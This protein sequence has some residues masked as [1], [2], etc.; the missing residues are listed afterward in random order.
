MFPSEARERLAVLG[1]LPR[2]AI[3]PRRSEWSAPDWGF[4]WA[5]P[6]SVQSMLGGLFDLVDRLG[7]VQDYGDPIDLDTI[8]SAGKFITKIKFPLLGLDGNR[9][10]ID[11]PLK[12]A[13]ATPP[14]LTHV[15]GFPYKH[16]VRVHLQNYWMAPLSPGYLHDNRG[17]AEISKPFVAALFLGLHELGLTYYPPFSPDGYLSPVDAFGFAEVDV[18]WL[19]TEVEKPWRA[20]VEGEKTIVQL[21]LEEDHLAIPPGNPADWKLFGFTRSLTELENLMDGVPGGDVAA[22]RVF[23]WLEAVS[24]AQVIAE[25][26]QLLAI[27]TE[28]REQLAFA[29][30]SFDSSLAAQLRS[31]PVLISSEAVA[32]SRSL[33]SLTK[34]GG[35]L[36]RVDASNSDAERLYCHHVSKLCEDE[37]ATIHLAAP[38]CGVDINL[39]AAF[40]LWQAGGAVRITEDGFIVGIGTSY[41]VGESYT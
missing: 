21:S 8:V 34:I 6:G 5:G 32:G 33:K 29:V 39:Q 2:G 36:L 28:L 30:S 18:D 31:L 25:D 13:F 40:D 16:V 26:D 19:R 27:T 15:S 22:A 3:V 10:G 9:A 1:K 20:V 41:W 4:M 35:Q 24:S 17:W 23:A 37:F 12:L 7:G 38:V 11:F 14:D